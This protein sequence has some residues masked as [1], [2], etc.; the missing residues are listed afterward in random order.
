MIEV[1]VKRHSQKIS[2]GK[3]SV[4]ELPQASHR[5]AS[6]DETARYA[7]LSARYLERLRITGDG[8]PFCKIGRRVVYDL[9]EI[10]RW[11][12]GRKVASTSER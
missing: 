3:A 2:D 6:C 10:D 12:N 7:R 1:P 4:G 5:W 9:G 8:P 11:L